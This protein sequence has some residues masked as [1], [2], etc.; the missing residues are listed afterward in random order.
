MVIEQTETLIREKK[1]RTSVIWSRYKEGLTTG[2]GSTREV[3][4][5]FKTWHSYNRDAGLGGPA[6]SRGTPPSNS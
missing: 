4:A 3:R 2:S 1:R 6:D 5:C